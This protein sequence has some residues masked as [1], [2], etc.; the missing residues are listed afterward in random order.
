[1]SRTI[2][3]WTLDRIGTAAHIDVAIGHSE[4]VAQ[5]CRYNDVCEIDLSCVLPSGFIDN[6]DRWLSCL[7]ADLMRASFCLGSTVLRLRFG[8][9]A[10]LQF[11]APKGYGVSRRTGY[12]L[13]VLPQIALQD[14]AIPEVQP[15]HM[16]KQ[17]V[18]VPLLSRIFQANTLGLVGSITI[19]DLATLLYLGLPVEGWTDY[20]GY[21]IGDVQEPIGVFFVGPRD[22]PVVHVGLAGIVPWVRRTRH[23]LSAAVALIQTLHELGATSVEF[24]VDN[25]NIESKAIAVRRGA[26]PIYRVLVMPLD[27]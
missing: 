25:R 12:V 18:I 5:V 4:I 9:S 2:R 11:S 21:L 27:I 24:E 6:N 16:A 8:A 26:C 23:G 10:H 7:L 13:D 20:R 22:G 19:S 14:I 3:R 17:H 1:M 15:L